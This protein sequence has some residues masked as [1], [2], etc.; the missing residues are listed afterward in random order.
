MSATGSLPH[1]VPPS[2]KV[3]TR[4][5]DDGRE[6]RTWVYDTGDKVVVERNT[7]FSPNGRP[8]KLGERE[9][10]TLEA[11]SMDIKGTTYNTV[12]R[13]TFDKSKGFDLKRVMD[14]VPHL[15]EQE[16]KCP[17]C[18]KAA[19]AASPLR[20]ADTPSPPKKTRARAAP[21]APR[22]APVDDWTLPPGVHAPP[23]PRPTPK[24]PSEGPTAP[25]VRPFVDPPG[26]GTG[27]LHFAQEE[28]SNLRQRYGLGILPS[29]G[30]GAHG[31]KSSGADLGFGLRPHVFSGLLGEAKEGAERLRTKRPR[32]SDLVGNMV[33]F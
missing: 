3:Y 7:D 8:T 16:G 24:A 22:K 19:N 23:R 17:H 30:Q 33:D 4:T 20:L 26:P 28:R 9:G 2:A 5:M 29:M 15:L 25:Q 14:E 10:V 11:G 6:D 18:Q 13:V 31:G 1:G 21:K 27:P 32:V 12:R